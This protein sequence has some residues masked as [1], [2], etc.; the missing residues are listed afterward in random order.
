MFEK[1]FG[2]PSMVIFLRAHRAKLL[3][4][5]KAS[6]IG[7]LGDWLWKSERGLVVEE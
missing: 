7:V 2:L 4:T 1:Y 6:R 5:L 3:Q